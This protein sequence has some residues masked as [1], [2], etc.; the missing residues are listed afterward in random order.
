MVETPATALNA[1][2]AAPLELDAHG[3]SDALPDLLVEARRV[4]QTVIHGIHGRRKSGPG[5][6]FWQFRQFGDGD[7]RS[8][9]DWRRS[10]ASDHLFIREREWEAAH[11]VWLW[12]DLSASMAFR[13]KLA[14]VLKRD[15]AV[16]LALALSALLARGGERVGLLGGQPPRTGRDMIERLA[17]EM[18]DLAKAGAISGLP[19]ADGPRRHQEVVMIGDFL[20]PLDVVEARLAEI[21]AMGVNGHIVQIVDPAEETLPYDGRVEFLPLEDGA[22]VIA[23]RVDGLRE[24]YLE[25]FSAHRS[26]LQT[27]A[28]S[29]GWSFI[30]HHTDRPAQEVLLAVTGRLSGAHGDYRQTASQSG[31]GGKRS[32]GAFTA[33]P[34]LEVVS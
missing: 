6:T 9:V 32:A 10:G 12:P 14:P 13:S 5:E 4:A 20:D 11:S 30:V 34:H 8:Q 1:E 23:E 2:T 26:A 3:L 31:A 18:V 28:R 7:T 27:L 29:Y 33:R 25:K 17:F 22:R 24:A 16:V 21:G 19:P 15:R